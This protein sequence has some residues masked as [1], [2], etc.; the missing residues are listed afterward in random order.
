VRHKPPASKAFMRCVLVLTQTISSGIHPTRFLQD[1]LDR[2]E[3]LHPRFWACEE[4]SETRLFERSKRPGWDG[5]LLSSHPFFILERSVMLFRCPWCQSE[6]TRRSK[7]RGFFEAFLARLTVRPFR[8]QDCDCRFFRRSASLRSH[9]GASVGSGPF[10][11]LR[12]T[13]ETPAASQPK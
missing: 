5:S 1:L 11:A 2:H 4:S 10:S 12:T 7:T 6:R 8:C 13:P 9:T 3:S